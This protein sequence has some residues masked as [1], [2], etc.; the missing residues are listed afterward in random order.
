MNSLIIVDSQFGFTKRV[1]QAILSGIPLTEKITLLEVE[2][3][4]NS[5]LINIDLLIVGSPTQ[6]GR[7]KAT[8][9][10]F[11]DQIPPNGLKNISVAAFD[12]RFLEEN[13]N[14]ALKILVRTIGYAAPKIAADLELKGGKLIAK[15]EGFI[16]MGREG[17]L[18]NG[19][20][21]RAKTWG[22]LLVELN[23]QSANT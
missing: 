14:F 13:L 10:T 19:E 9:Q 17:P 1:A 6:G 20:L 8:L 21:E 12:T 3:V 11:L 4:T 2:Q 5:S 18:A 16:V 15:P 22:A 7:A 23:S